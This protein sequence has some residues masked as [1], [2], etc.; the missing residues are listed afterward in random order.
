MKFLFF[1][2]PLAT[3]NQP[4]PQNIRQSHQFESTFSPTDGF[5]IKL[6]EVT[7]GGDYMCHAK[8]DATGEFDQHYS[9][10]VNCEL[11]KCHGYATI[12][13]DMPATTVVAP[14]SLNQITTQSTPHLMTVTTTTI[15]ASNPMVK[16][17]RSG[18]GK[19][20]FKKRHI[21]SNFSTASTV[22]TPSN[23]SPS[24]RSSLSSTSSA[25]VLQ[26]NQHLSVYDVEITTA[27][28]DPITTARSIDLDDVVFSRRFSGR[29][30]VP[31]PSYIPDK[32]K[33]RG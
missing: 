13:N 18:V 29:T 33:R 3:K 1:F 31:T 8:I 20:S 23:P 27:P 4:K 16:Q 5:R 28:T 11:N 14:I 2:L 26:S 7:D 10:H 19:S 17:I 32:S 24:K 21:S 9:V 30:L 22:S 25:S 12:V 6:N 15:I